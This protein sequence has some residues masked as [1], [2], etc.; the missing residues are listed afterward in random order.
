MLEL[1][2]TDLFLNTIDL[3][4]CIKNT[5]RFDNN[6]AKFYAAEIFLGLSFLHDKRIVYRDLKPENVLIGLDGHA[7][8]ADFGF[9]KRI[10][11]DTTTFCGTPS[12]IAP[13]VIRRIPYGVEV[14]WWSFGILIF[15][16]LSGCSP[17]QDENSRK[18]YDRILTERIRWPS[19]PSKYFNDDAYDIINCLLVSNSE[20]R[21]GYEDDGEISEHIWFTGTDWEA[22]SNQLIRPPANMIQNVRKR[23]ESMKIQEHSFRG[24]GDILNRL[25]NGDLG[26]KFNSGIFIPPNEAETVLSN[27]NLNQEQSWN[28]SEASKTASY[29]DLF[30]DF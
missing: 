30:A 14:D 12:Y 11:K 8:L 21:L 22:M 3:F 28:G 26:Q 27:Q 6:S 23:S 7:K 13:E 1:G 29:T 25:G 10:P 24:S 18:T 15:E 5:G 17:F 19:N 9:A 20:D 16:L 4:S 2:K